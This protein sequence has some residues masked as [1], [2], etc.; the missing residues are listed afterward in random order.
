MPQD[1]VTMAETR[2]PRRHVTATHQT[3]NRPQ[4][5]ENAPDATGDTDK[6]VR[7]G[8]GAHKGQRAGGTR[9]ARHFLNFIL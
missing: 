2:P 3:H 6:G 1:T 8:R 7:E 9:Y 5:V 4:Q